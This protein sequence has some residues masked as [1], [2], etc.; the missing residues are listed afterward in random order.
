MK[1]NWLWEAR[2]LDGKVITQP[3]D[4]KYSKHDDSKDWNPSSYRDFLDYFDGGKNKLLSFGIANKDSGDV[5]IVKLDEKKPYIFSYHDGDK[6]VN[7]L[8]HEMQE[9]HD[10][11]PI[12]Y[13]EMENTVVD[14]VFGEPNV[15]A[16]NV[17]YQGKNDTGA[18]VK[19]IHRVS[20]I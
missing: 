5:V 17:G 19:H 3:E 1:L 11:Q 7:D 9:L 6:N 2:F 18:N 8:Y 13:R 14:G 10:V 4:D 12:Y 15:V 20:V 16:Y